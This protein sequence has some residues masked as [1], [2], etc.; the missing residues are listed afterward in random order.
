V[1]VPDSRS[2]LQH[3]LIK[4]HSDEIV[5]LESGGIEE[6]YIAVIL[7][8]VLKGLECLHAANRAHKAIRAPKILFSTTGSAV[9]SK[10]LISW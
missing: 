4:V 5:Q 9:N 6:Q 8:E 7:R 3:V 2:R 10:F 1:H